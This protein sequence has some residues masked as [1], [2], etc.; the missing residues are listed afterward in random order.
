MQTSGLKVWFWS[1]HLEALVWFNAAASGMTNSVRAKDTRS[2]VTVYDRSRGVL[3]DQPTSS[4]CNAILCRMQ[5]ISRQGSSHGVVPFILAILLL[6]INRGC[7]CIIWRDRTCHICGDQVSVCDEGM[8]L[9]GSLSNAEA[10]WM[11][12]FQERPLRSLQKQGL[13]LESKKIN[14]SSHT[15]VFVESW[16]RESGILKL[17]CVIFSYHNSVTICHFTDD[18]VIWRVLFFQSSVLLKFSVGNIH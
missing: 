10:A 16:K 15:L 14:M 13:F 12:W 1:C 6:L 4:S 11:C 17:H 18:T 8:S 7:V 5:P 3:R 2:N 9:R